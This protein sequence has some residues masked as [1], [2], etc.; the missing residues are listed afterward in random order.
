MLVVKSSYLKMSLWAQG[1]YEHFSVMLI[2]I[3]QIA[4]LINLGI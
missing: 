2:I 4:K 1:N 3:L